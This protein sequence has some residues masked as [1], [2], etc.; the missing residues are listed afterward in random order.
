MYLI[1]YFFLYLQLLFSNSHVSFGS[2]DYVEF[3]SKIIGNR[4]IEIYRPS[5]QQIS[6]KTIFIIMH[7]GQMLFD[8]T[9]T[10]NR[11]DWN[12]DGIF[13]Q[14]KNRN[15]DIVIIGVSSINKSG[16]GF[17]D[18]T[19]RYA[20]YFPKESI[21]YFKKILKHIFTISI[22]IKISLII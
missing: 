21:K 11:K 19:K 15:N 18:N 7:D 12:I 14:R 10:W 22:L 3:E 5:N 20:E 2:I 8:S 6:D 9:I 1:I 13:E 16:D 17:I 4:S